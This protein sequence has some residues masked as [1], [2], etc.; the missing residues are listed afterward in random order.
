MSYKTLGRIVSLSLLCATL[1]LLAAC[2]SGLRSG[3]LQSSEFPS[4]PGETIK[5]YLEAINTR[6][7]DWFVKYMKEVGKRTPP[8][9]PGKKVPPPSEEQEDHDLRVWFGTITANVPN[10][11]KPSS[12]VVERED[13]NGNHA[14]VRVTIHRI[15]GSSETRDFPLTYVGGIW[16]MGDLKEISAIPT[17][18]D[19]WS[20]NVFLGASL[21]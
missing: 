20:V 12:I 6:N 2:G 9:L 19:R 13:V 21:S 4:S 8:N 14:T 7:A 17:R 15:N 18:S 1:L 5:Q 16:A 10:G 3:V 11:N